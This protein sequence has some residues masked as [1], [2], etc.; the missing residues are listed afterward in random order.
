MNILS[1]CTSIV[2]YKVEGKID[3]SVMEIVRQGLKKNLIRDIDSN[4]SELSIGWTSSEK[5][6]NP[7][8]I[9]SSLSIANYLIFSLRIDKKSIPSKIF[10]KH[11]AAAITKKLAET[12]QEYL[13]K[14]EKQGI[15]D[16]VNNTLFLRIPATPNIYD[17]I[18]NYEEKILLFFSTLKVA[19]QELETLFSKSFKLTLIRLFPYTAANF[20]MGLSDSDKDVVSKLS[21]TSFVSVD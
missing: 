11:C 14:N 3:G 13:S 2:R 15:K 7:E 16:H 1:S 19:N 10:K 6:F 9:E 20:I 18:W 4:A 12:G 5:P 8:L 17:L 21:Q